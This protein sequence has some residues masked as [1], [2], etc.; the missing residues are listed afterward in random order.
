MTAKPK[1]S[2]PA[3]KGPKTKSVASKER[4]MV[5]PFPETDDP[6]EAE[7]ILAEG[8]PEWEKLD[9]EERAEL[10]QLITSHRKRRAPVEVKLISRPGG[11][12]SIDPA[13]KNDMLAALKLHQTFAANSLHPVNARAAE[14]IKYLESVGACNDGRYNA[15]LSFIESMGP[16]DQA[17]ALLLVQMYVTHDAAIRALSMLGSAEWVPTVQ[18]Y[19]NLATKLLRVSQGQM[20]TLARMRR[21]GEQVVKH[22]HVDNRGVQA[23]IAESVH[24]G[25]QG[26]GKN[27][28][29]PHEQSPCGAALLGHDP[30]A[31]GM[32]IT[33]IEREEAV[34]V[35][36]RTVAGRS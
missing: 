28:T 3:S 12:Y 20:E 10:A 17:E 34:P 18:T 24:N 4:T 32:P 9:S 16:K 2:R 6:K 7:R 21:G 30:Q 26:N 5:V 19:G 33:G 1:S 11:G 25:G 35:A 8:V 23:V 31:F 29:Q 15:A 13:G 27:D 36:R 14:L 22:I